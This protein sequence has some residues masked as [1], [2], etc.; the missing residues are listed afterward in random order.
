MED[1]RIAVEGLA[2]S[3]DAAG[4]FDLVVSADRLEDEADLQVTASGYGPAVH[5][6]VPNAGQT[7]VILRRA[8][9]SAGR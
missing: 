2:V 9:R 3:T 6:V 7:V 8:I 5:K 1:A 4:Q